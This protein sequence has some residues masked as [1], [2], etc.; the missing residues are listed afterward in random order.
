M[1]LR[2]RKNGGDASVQEVAEAWKKE[3]HKV[4]WSQSELDEWA[5]GFA[6]RLKD[7]DMKAGPAKPDHRNIHED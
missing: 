1:L 6:K 4:D 5:V 3:A 7:A 2:T